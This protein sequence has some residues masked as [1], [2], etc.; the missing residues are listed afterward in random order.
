[1]ELASSRLLPVDRDTAWRALMDPEQ[2]RAAIPGCES[3]EQS[4]E[5]EYAVLLTAAIG[6][7]KA[8]FRGKLRLGDVVA[9][10]RYTIDFEGQ[11]GQAGFGKGSARV[12]L[13][14][15]GGHTRLTYQASAQVGGRIAQVGQ[16]LVDAAAGRLADEFFEAF[17]SSLA[18]GRGIVSNASTDRPSVAPLW[19]GAALVV[20]LIVLVLV[21][22]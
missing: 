17:S 12:E 19:F 15:E 5:G 22:R 13:H 8:K 16:R 10:E 11:G 20:L 18:A 3:I 9:P 1:M 2:L 7:V 6:P 21:L 14:P 4:A